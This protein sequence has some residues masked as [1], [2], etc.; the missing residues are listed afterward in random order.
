MRL[1]YHFCK[2]FQKKGMIFSGMS[3]N[4]DLPEILELNCHPW[5]F[6]VQFHPELKSKPFEPH[7]LFSSF[8]K[9]CLDKSRL[10]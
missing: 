7:P 5:F 1:I 10:I 9:A 3:P 2:S 4:K 6:G 8:I